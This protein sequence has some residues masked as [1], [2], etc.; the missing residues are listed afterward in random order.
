MDRPVEFGKKNGFKGMV[1]DRSKHPVGLMVVE[2]ES[3]AGSY[4]L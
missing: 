3:K 2:A 1:L 4:S